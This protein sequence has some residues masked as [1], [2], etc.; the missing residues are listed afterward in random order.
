MQSEPPI[1]KWVWAPPLRKPIIKGRPLVL[2]CITEGPLELGN[3]CC[4]CGKPSA[5]KHAVKVVETSKAQVIVHGATMLAGPIGHIVTG[6]Q[7]LTQEKVKI[8]CCSSCRA[9]HR[10]G[11]AAG[12]A[13]FLLAAGIFAGLM[14]MD[15]AARLRMPTWV[16]FT[17]IV[18]CFVLVAVGCGVSALFDW[19]SLSVMIYRVPGGLMYYE[20][21]SDRYYDFLKVGDVRCQTATRF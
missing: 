2:G 19:R 5:K 16:T 18:G 21:W 17:I 7:Q 9:L 13:L 4:R 15:D 14:S 10:W 20:F 12:I 1:T 11:L 6:I 3:V 8:P